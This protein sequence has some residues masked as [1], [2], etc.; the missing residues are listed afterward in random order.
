M[1]DFNYLWNKLKNNVGKKYKYNYFIPELWIEKDSTRKINVDPYDF[2]SERLD[3][4][5]ELSK[6]K[7]SDCDIVYNLFV[8]YATS[9][10]HLGSND[11]LNVPTDHFRQTGT[12]L[13]SIAIL[14]YLKNLG[15]GTIYLLPVTS[16]GTYG[17]KGNLGSPYSINNPYKL[18]ESLAEPL[19]EMTV[20]QQY[21]AF[22]EAAKLLGM[23]VVMEFVF[24]T[25]SIDSELALLHPEWFYWIY[26][27]E[28]EFRPPKFDEETLKIIKQKIDLGD[29]DNLPLPSSNYL[30]KFAKT[31][32]RVL[33]AQNGKIIGYTDDEKQLTIPSAFADWPPDDNQPLWTD[34]TYLK[35]HN[36]PDFNFIAYNTVRMY[37][38]ILEQPEYENASLWEHIKQIV[39]YYINYFGIDGAMVDMGHAMP[40]K[41]MKSIIEHA[42][43]I[44]P[45]FIFWEENFSVTSKSK[46][47][48]YDAALGYVPFDSHNCLKM[49]E[50]ISKFENK[51]FPINFFLTPENHNTKRAASREGSTDFSKMIWLVLSF[52]PSIKFIHNGFEL[53]ERMPVN[54]GLGF[55]EDE[56][57]QFPTERL[58]LFSAIALD[59]TNSDNLVYYIQ[60]VNSALKYL[61]LDLKIT[62]FENFKLLETGE[63]LLAFMIEKKILCVANYSNKK[64]ELPLEELKIDAEIYHFNIVNHTRQK[65]ENSILLEAFTG[66]I[67]LL[68]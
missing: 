56:I 48:G 15:V 8:R 26:D 47:E 40:E 19:L 30:N 38:R 36:H 42:R 54:T 45:D 55:A 58:P 41:L 68:E 31:P 65:A 53:G 4:I 59:W 49:K 29:F 61:K 52:L 21:K 24:R 22:I 18:D 63:N 20:E 27:T 16:I 44:K 33:Y 34:V 50:I 43:K 62:N 25:A 23:K 5:L 13:K 67:F 51:E 35:L 17:K 3:R 14:P 57:K 39:P 32:R 60:Q 12:F 2:F 1:T 46:E 64:L 9:F 10:D 6:E 66:S 28:E 7:S 37:D 11:L